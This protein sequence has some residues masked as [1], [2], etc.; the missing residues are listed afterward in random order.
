MGAPQTE[1]TEGLAAWAGDA[2]VG[3]RGQLYRERCDSIHSEHGCQCDL[4]EGHDGPHQWGSR[5]IWLEWERRL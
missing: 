4:V 5:M 3:K 1:Q 2:G